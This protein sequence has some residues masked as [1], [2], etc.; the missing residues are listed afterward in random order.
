MASPFRCG[1]LAPYLRKV[2]AVPDGETFG[3][4]R[5][6]GDRITAATQPQT[7]A[8]PQ[9]G[10]Q[11]PGRPQS[12]DRHSVRIEERH[13]LGDAA[14]GDG[15]RVGDDLLAPAAGLAASGSVGKAPCNAV[16]PIARRGL[17]G[18]VAGLRGQRVG[19]SRGRWGKRRDPILRTGASWGASITCSPRPRERRCRP[20]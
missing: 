2:E 20:S 7:A 16:V 12:P 13:S 18:L 3:K 8:V 4:R 14:P 17:P 6:V 10:T 1:A 15:M 9:S 5:A 11:A 19:A